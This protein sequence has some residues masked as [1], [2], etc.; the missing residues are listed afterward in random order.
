MPHLDSLNG[1]IFPPT[2][3]RRQ[4]GHR[5][6]GPAI[7]SGLPEKQGPG[8]KGHP[9]HDVGYNSARKPGRCLCRVRGFHPQDVKGGGSSRLLPS[10]LG[11]T[12]HQASSQASDFSILPLFWQNRCCQ[13]WPARWVGKRQQMDGQTPCLQGPQPQA[14]RTGR[15]TPVSPKASTDSLRV[16]LEGLHPRTLLLILKWDSA[17]E[18]SLASLGA[19]ASWPLDNVG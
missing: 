7:P 16:C 12:E 11:T 3:E 10:S 6:T 8:C 19:H 9:S 5:L 17:L 2:Q 18:F 1:L 15:D 4:Q 14:V 13:G